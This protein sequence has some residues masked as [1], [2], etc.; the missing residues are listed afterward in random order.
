VLEK[1]TLAAAPAAGAGAPPP[2]AD[3][4]EIAELLRTVPPPRPVDERRLPAPVAPPAAAGEPPAAVEIPAFDEI[5]RAAGIDAPAHGFTAFKVLEILD[6][7]ELAALDAKAKAGA[8][9]AF[10]KMNPAG[11]VPIGD[12]VQDAVR[13]DQA[14]DQFERFLQGKLT[15]RA[16]AA[17][18]DNAA[19]QSEL[20][21]L[22]RRNRERMEANRRAVDAARERFEAW[23]AAKRD[24]ERR[25]A[26]AVAPFVDGN[27]VTRSQ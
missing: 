24:E 4:P 23:R 5:Y 8:L 25:L 18:R 11:A 22:A 9:A 13:R 20:D 17:D 21:E 1:I 6:T 26:E 15:E 27:P 14:L 3:P 7:P 16:T 12:I 2:A 19:L 10:L